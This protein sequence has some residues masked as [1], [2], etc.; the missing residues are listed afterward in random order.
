M[1]RRGLARVGRG[2][3]EGWPKVGR[4]EPACRRATQR[5]LGRERRLSRHRPVASRRSRS[6]TRSSRQ[7]C[8][9]TTAAA[10]R[11]SL[12]RRRT[13]RAVAAAPSRR[14][15]APARR[16]R[17]SPSRRGSALSPP[18]LLPL[19]LSFVVLC[20]PLSMCDGARPTAP[21]HS[22]IPCHDPDSC[23]CAGGGRGL[24]A[25]LLPVSRRPCD[26]LRSHA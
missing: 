24:D 7:T 6:S 26:H 21:V 8:A 23:C 15:D 20:S 16:A 17:F 18:P 22:R 19:P 12:P 14:G 25:S 3:G 13:E 1:S 2:L 9:P 10:A 11:C 4:D 5:S